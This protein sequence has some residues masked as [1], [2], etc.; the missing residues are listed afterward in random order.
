MT[1]LTSGL[2]A[3]AFMCICGHLS[4]GAL[5]FTGGMAVLACYGWLATRG[6][7]WRLLAIG[8]SIL[9]VLLLLKNVIDVLWLGHNPVFR[10]RF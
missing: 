4:A 8:F 6:L 9:P 3:P 7:F 2:L 5:V 1:T 10:N